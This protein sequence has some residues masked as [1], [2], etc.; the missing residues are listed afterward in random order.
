MIF[1]GYQGVGKSTIAEHDIISID[2]ES[3]NFWYKLTDTSEPIRDKLWYIPY[4]N[5]AESLSLQGYNV[6]V[7]SHE[8]V[9]KQLANSIEH[10]VAIVPAIEL[11]DAWVHKLARRYE[12]SGLDKDYKAWM[13]AKDRYEANI[14]EIKQD[15]KNIIE[16]T[17]MQYDLSLLIHRYLRKF[18]EGETYGRGMA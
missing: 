2:L 6:F 15:C 9:R 17:R 12:A 5:I 1:I 14:Q 11:K 7:S 10:V 4:C 13:N 18:K 16:I 8:C 3:G